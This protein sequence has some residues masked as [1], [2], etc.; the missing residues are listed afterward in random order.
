MQ[1]DLQD[2]HF[3]YR[4]EHEILHGVDLT[5]AGTDPIA[6]IGQ[7]GAGKTTLVKQFNGILTPTSGH[8]LIDGQDVTTQ[9]TAKWSSKV[10]YV[11]QNPNDQLFLDSV[12]KEFEFGP[13]RIGMSSAE[14]KQRVDQVAEL[15]ELT[16]DLDTHPFDLDDTQKKF[17]TIGAIIMMN[18]DVVVFDE[19]TCGQDVHGDHLLNHI[20]Q[21]LT[22]EGKLC[23]TISHD[24]KFVSQ[25]FK[26]VIVMSQ[27]AVQL[28]GTPEDVFSQTA[29][30]KTCFIT[31]PP[32]TQLAQTVGFT[33]T[34]FTTDAFVRAFEEERK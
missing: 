13:K 10:G 30:L 2:L 23:V 3:G 27:G 33:A 8:V 7:N 14:I 24:M 9:T 32:L 6:I 4:P 28:D 34:P 11:F 20:I 15:V 5:L 29:T 22:A 21:H 1:I 17:C 18:P 19:P 12:R 25:N 26:R 31:P 16:D